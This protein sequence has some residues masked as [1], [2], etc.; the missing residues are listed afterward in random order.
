MFE[1]GGPL[2]PQVIS[3]NH[4]FFGKDVPWLTFADDG[5]LEWIVERMARLLWALILVSFENG[6][7]SRRRSLLEALK[8]ETKVATKDNWGYPVQKVTPKTLINSNNA[9]Y[10]VP[11]ITKMSSNVHIVVRMG[12][13]GLQKGSFESNRMD[14]LRQCRST[15]HGGSENP[16]TDPPG[17]RLHLPGYEKMNNIGFHT[18][19]E[20]MVVLLKNRVDVLK[21]L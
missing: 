6:A 13:K 8:D 16:K 17:R 12:I 19:L 7:I 15:V 3:W 4:S 2:P 10:D 18:V 14:A 21:F 9:I 1:N 11:Y 20:L 5:Y